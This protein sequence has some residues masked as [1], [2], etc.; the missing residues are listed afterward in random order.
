MK[1]TF[2]HE[3]TYDFDEDATINEIAA[4]LVANERFIKEAVGVIQACHPNLEISGLK[5]KLSEVTQNSPLKELVA[6]TMVIAFQKDLEEEVPDFIQ[7]LT[8][9]DVTD[10]Y[11]TIVTV[12]VVAVALYG[13]LA[14][15]ERTLKSKKTP[16][17]IEAYN[18]VTNVAGDLIQ[19]AP[20]TFREKME[21]R[22]GGGK[23]RSISKNARDFFLPAKKRHARS[24]ETSSE[25]QIDAN[26]IDEIPSEV[27]EAAIDEKLDEYDLDSVTVLLR[28]HDLDSDK[29]GWAG[30]IK[31]VSEERVKVH[32]D[33]AIP[34]EKLFDKKSVKA[35][36]RV[37]SKENENGEMLPYLYVILEV[38]V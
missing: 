38:L 13:G 6:V 1:K 23:N 16:K 20:E 33:P 17:M 9:I 7:Y 32:K 19:V 27:D 2:I 22:L 12:G 25:V 15:I 30:V 26:V 4:S 11:D 3:V 5:I 8:G 24:I 10:K 28:A 35:N 14:L 37:Y 21:E 34:A 29:A 18:N 31:D 36:V